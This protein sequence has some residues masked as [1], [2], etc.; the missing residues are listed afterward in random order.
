[1]FTEDMRTGEDYSKLKKCIHI[2]ILD[3]NLTQD[4]DYHRVYRLQDVKG[5]RFSDL[6]EIHIV[7]LRKGLQGTDRLDDWIRFFNAETKEELDMIQ[8][9]NPGILEAVKE[10][11]I[12][13]LGNRL[14][15]RYEA[16]MKIVRDRKARED[17]VRKEGRQAERLELV[18]GKLAKGQT[19]E[20]IAE[21]LLDTPEHIRELIEML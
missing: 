5:N 2:S 10:V 7:E 15:L 1:M 17:Y 6:L 20:Q 4:T 11:K 21:D 16:H 18:Q 8:T 14:R 9:T 13:S 19:V 3:F 12:M